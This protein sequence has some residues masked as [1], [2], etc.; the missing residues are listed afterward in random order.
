MAWRDVLDQCSTVQT[1]IYR[2]DDRKMFDSSSNIAD[3]L[4]YFWLKSVCKYDCHRAKRILLEVIA[5]STQLRIEKIK[6]FASSCQRSFFFYACACDSSS[7]AFIS[8]PRFQHQ[9]STVNKWFSVSAV[10]DGQGRKIN[11]INVD[12]AGKT[13]KCY[14]TQHEYRN[15]P[16]SLEDL[17]DYEVFYHGT[18]HQSAATIMKNIDLSRGKTGRDFS[19]NDGFYLGK[20]FDVVL[21][22]N[23]ARNRPPNSAVLV[24]LV[25][26]DELRNQELRSTNLEDNMEEWKEVVRL[27][28]T[29]QDSGKSQKE[30]RNDKRSIR[31]I[32]TTYD[33]L[34]GPMSS[35][36][37]DF[38]HPE[39]IQDSYQLCVRSERCAELFDRSLHSVVFFDKV[40]SES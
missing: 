1:V 24:Y 15:F 28:R 5:W 6:T 36:K 4:G 10:G 20:N 11:V 40:K 2:L 8:Y 35:D 3:E 9:P 21:E 31:T 18:N 25:R 38:T 17:E 26:R 7:G 19:S 27:F 30:S 32:R 12:Q 16:R 23:W 39:P 29:E 22:T 33:F 37:R 13:R 14:T 34:E